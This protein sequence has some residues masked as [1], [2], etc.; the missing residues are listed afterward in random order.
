M[1]LADFKS[2]MPRDERGR[3]V[4]L[5]RTPANV[6]VAKIDQMGPGAGATGTF[7]PFLIGPN[8]HE[9]LLLRGQSVRRRVGFMSTKPEDGRFC[10]KPLI[11]G[12]A[13]PVRGDDEPREK[14]HRQGPGQLEKGCG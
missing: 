11:L 5:P 14:L 9:L 4:R 13:K 6:F 7:R 2:V 3:W 12:I 8:V 1:A 10:V